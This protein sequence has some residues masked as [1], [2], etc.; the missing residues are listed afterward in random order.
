MILVAISFSSRFSSVVLVDTIRKVI[1]ETI[2][3]F[4]DIISM[5]PVLV[6]I[7]IATSNAR[8]LMIRAIISPRA[9][10][11]ALVCN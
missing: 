7:S 5:D 11:F 2:I 6:T 3:V 1:T 8:R 4:V 10:S 9:N